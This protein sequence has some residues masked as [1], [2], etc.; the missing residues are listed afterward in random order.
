M[1]LR[2]AFTQR[3]VTEKGHAGP[4][5]WFG[6]TEGHR[7][8]KLAGDVSARARESEAVCSQLH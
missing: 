5:L 3:T 8:G 1:G 4:R 6:L 2:D 7:A